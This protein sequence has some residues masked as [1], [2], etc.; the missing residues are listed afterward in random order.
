MSARE[1][2]PLTTAAGDSSSPVTPN[3]K[4]AKMGSPDHA[5]DTPEKEG[6]STERAQPQ[7]SQSIDNAATEA[8]QSSENGNGTDVTPP[9]PLATTD[10]DNDDLEAA[11]PSRILP[12]T[13]TNR[14]TGGGIR[15]LGFWY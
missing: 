3:L 8:A 12:S 6:Q 9:Q 7:K 4:R 13:P 11:S 10:E 5:V 1:T 2:T 14:A 15:R